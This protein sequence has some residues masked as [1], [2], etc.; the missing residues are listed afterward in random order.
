MLRLPLTHRVSEADGWD[1]DTVGKLG[2]SEWVGQV[3][4]QPLRDGAALEGMA[5]GAHD[6]IAEALESDGAAHVWRCL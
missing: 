3:V 6:W 4:A 5:V 2:A 1:Q